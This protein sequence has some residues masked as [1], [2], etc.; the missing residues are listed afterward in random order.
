[1]ADGAAGDTW[2]PEIC[3]GHVT[4]RQAAASPVTTLD[5]FW[6][7]PRLDCKYFEPDE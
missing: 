3:L 2:R 4:P 7:G 1:M 5:T 6:L